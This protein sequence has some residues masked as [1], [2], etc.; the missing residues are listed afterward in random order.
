MNFNAVR[1]MGNS[2]KFRVWKC[3]RHLNFMTP[4]TWGI[5][6]TSR[7]SIENDRLKTLSHTFS[8][9]NWLKYTARLLCTGNSASLNRLSLSSCV[10]AFDYRVT[11]TL[12]T[13]SFFFFFVSLT[14]TIAH[15]VYAWFSLALFLGQYIYFK[16]KLSF[17]F[18]WN[19]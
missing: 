7:C 16:L 14:T 6:I 11:K 5:N 1:R 9:E 13:I 3:I 12:H 17:F 19:K 18:L 2:L 4:S 15:R 8:P 10:Y